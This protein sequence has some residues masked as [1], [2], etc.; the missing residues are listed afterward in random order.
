MSRF[1]AEMIHGM[2]ESMKSP[3]P[4]VLTL[5]QAAALLQLQEDTLRRM[6]HEGRISKSVKRRYPLRFLRE[7]LVLEYMCIAKRKTKSAPRQDPLD[8]A[9]DILPD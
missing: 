2:F 9:H 7:G 4:P 3:L 8:T 1:R 5:E 6:V